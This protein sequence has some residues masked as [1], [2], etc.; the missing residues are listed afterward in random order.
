MKRHYF[1]FAALAVFVPL[2]FGSTGVQAEKEETAWD[3]DRQIVETDGA[4]TYHAYISNNEKNAWIHKID[5]DT[6]EEHSTLSIPELLDGKIVT[7]L[8]YT[9]DAE[10]EP[11]SDYIPN[12]FGVAVEDY[13]NVD[14]SS[15]EVKG[16]ETLVIPDSVNM[17]QT[18]AFSGMDSLKTVQIPD[19][20]ESVESIIFY[21]CDQLKTVQ[22]PKNLKEL[23]AS[24]FRGCPKL[25]N[26]KLSAENKTYQIK[27]QCVIEKKSKTLTYVL[28]F[29]KTVD[30]P[31][32]VKRIKTYAFNNCVSSTI[33][34]PA[35]VTEI[36]DAAFHQTGSKQNTKIKNVAVSKKNKV[37]A[38]DGQCIYNKKNNSLSI[39]IVNDKG[40]LKISDKVKK[41]VNTY[42]MVNCDTEENSLKKVT[43]PKYLKTVSVPAFSLLSNAKK[44]YFTGKKPPEIKDEIEHYSPLP[45]FTDVYVP[46][47]SKADYQK[48]YK[49]YD[50]YKF[51][52]H[53]YTYK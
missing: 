4:F 6:K 25:R 43:F 17:I 21:G 28:P 14:G 22:L 12:L 48:W 37:Y 46:D 47:R 32:G 20:V 7:R 2:W 49:K 8:G 26:L 52:D 16:I 18:A 13:H 1:A 27:K 35:S 24:A 53:W 38:K 10:K 11:D 33:K 31:D 23:N 51:V 41:L 3:Y 44:V 39:A 45:I 40:K 34:I 42:S 30:I 9:M 19:D 29:G 50:C 36:E 5:I 15:E